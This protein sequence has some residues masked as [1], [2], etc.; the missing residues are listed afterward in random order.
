MPMTASRAF[1]KNGEYVILIAVGLTVVAFYAYKQ[2]SSRIF[3]Q[4]EAT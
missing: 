2:L 4:V 3:V 1:S